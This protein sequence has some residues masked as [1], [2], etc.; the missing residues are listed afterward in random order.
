MN[1]NIYFNFLKNDIINKCQVRKGI[2]GDL[3][4]FNPKKEGDI[5]DSRIVFIPKASIKPYNKDE[6]KLDKDYK[7]REN[8]TE[9]EIVPDLFEIDEN[10]EIEDN[11]I[12]DIRNS[13]RG[14]IDKS[15]DAS[16]NESLRRSIN[17]SYN[18]SMRNSLMSSINTEGQ[19]ILRR[20]KLAFEGSVN[21]EV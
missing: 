11:V 2:L 14:S 20:L 3:E 18:Q 6:I 9:K 4:Y 10:L 13:L 21:K 5:F 15:I 7:F 12:E 1:N 19:G 8:M 16:V 17:H